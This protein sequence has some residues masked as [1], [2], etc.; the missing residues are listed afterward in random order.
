MDKSKIALLT[1]KAVYASIKAG[2]EILKIYNDKT[3]DFK[4]EKKADNSPLTIADKAA[5][6]IISQILKDSNL[7]ILSEEGREINFDERKNWKHFWLIDPLDGTK[8]FIKKN[9]EFTVNIALINHNTPVL[10]VIF[11]PVL[12]ALYFTMGN[13]SYK[14]QPP[15]HEDTKKFDFNN[16]F[17]NSTKIESSPKNQKYTIIATRSHKTKEL[18]DF[19]SDLKEKHG[20]IDLISAGSS[21]KFCK[22]AEGSAHIYPRLGPTMEWDTGAGHVI[23]EK[24]G[25]IIK[26][27]DS[28][29]NLIYNKANL[30]N[31]NFIVKAKNL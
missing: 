25:C 21:L 18:E 20:D 19:V 11:A 7:P 27:Y 3:I 4:V 23:C 24:A 16:I 17:N 22:I 13:Y 26:K 1:E 8:E 9:G 28:D 15:V 5:H 31:P 29:D 30:R 2:H 14:Y 12:N 10:G 6:N